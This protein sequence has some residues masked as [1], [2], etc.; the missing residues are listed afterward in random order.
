MR[1]PTVPQNSS[2]RTLVQPLS[3]NT[4]RGASSSKE[5]DGTGLNRGACAPNYFFIFFFFFFAAMMR[6]LLV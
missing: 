4:A 3:R 2:G 6:F 1:R 5:V